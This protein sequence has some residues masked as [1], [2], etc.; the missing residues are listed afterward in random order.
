M[1]THLR[2]YDVCGNCALEAEFFGAAAAVHGMGLPAES[3]PPV[4]DQR[5]R[6]GRKKRLWVSRA[7]DERGHPGINANYAGVDGCFRAWEAL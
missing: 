1:L 5:L 4:P 3:F 6:T 7:C 2:S